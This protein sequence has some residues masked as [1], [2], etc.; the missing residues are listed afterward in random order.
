MPTQ[1]KKEEMPTPTPETT[2]DNW[3]DLSTYACKTCRFFVPKDDK[4]GRCRRHAPVVGEGYP[5]TYPSD[6][7]GDHKLGSAPS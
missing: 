3:R 2:K 5:V 1:V 4:V 6:W 7:C